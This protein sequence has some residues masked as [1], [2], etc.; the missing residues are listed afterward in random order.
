MGSQVGVGYAKVFCG[1]ESALSSREEGD[2]A[3]DKEDWVISISSEILGESKVSILSQSINPNIPSP[4]VMIPFFSS[5]GLFG[6]VN[7]LYLG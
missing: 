4:N 2:L 3:F 6:S 7:T 1:R 5:E